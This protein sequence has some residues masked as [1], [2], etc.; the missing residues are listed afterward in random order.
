MHPCR[1]LM[2]T[3][4]L[5]IVYHLLNHKFQSAPQNDLMAYNNWPTIYSTPFS[6]RTHWSCRKAIIYFFEMDKA[7]KKSLPYFQDFSN[8]KK[9][10][11]KTIKFWSSNKRRNIIEKWRRKTFLHSMTFDWKTSMDIKDKT[12]A[13]KEKNQKLWQLINHMLFVDT[14][15]YNKRLTL[16]KKQWWAFF[17][18][19][20]KTDIELIIKL[21][22]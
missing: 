13:V 4:K 2:P 12:L 10:L 11:N 14:A 19:K 20:L 21:E 6:C 7:C 15:V 22:K 18:L 16:D 3:W 8:I 5:L 17:S 9:K 1:S